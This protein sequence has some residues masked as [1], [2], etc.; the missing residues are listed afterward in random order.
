MRQETFSYAEIIANAK[1]NMKPL[2]A[3]VFKL[4]Q[5]IEGLTGV[6]KEEA[7]KDIINLKEKK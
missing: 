3:D 6:P 4:T 5:M 2:G 7:F 1:R